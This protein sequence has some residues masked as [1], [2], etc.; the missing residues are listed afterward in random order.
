MLSLICSYQAKCQSEKKVTLVP[1]IVK[2][3]SLWHLKHPFIQ[4]LS[5]IDMF[6]CVCTLSLRKDL[7]I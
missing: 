4:I 3:M 5:Q 6:A 1:P 2:M 7:N